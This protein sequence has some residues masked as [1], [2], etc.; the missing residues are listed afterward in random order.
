VDSNTKHLVLNMQL[1]FKQISALENSVRFVQLYPRLFRLLLLFIGG[2]VLWFLLLVSKVNSIRV[3][4]NI[5]TI[6]AAIYWPNVPAVNDR[7]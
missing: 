6:T 5:I 1:L 7:C 2:C 3:I 4:G